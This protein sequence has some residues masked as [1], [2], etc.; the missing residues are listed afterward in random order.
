MRKIKVDSIFT[1]NIKC[2]QHI[3]THVVLADESSYSYSESHTIVISHWT[4]FQSIWI[5]VTNGYYVLNV[6][7]E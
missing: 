5:G 4:Y 6:D 2:I 3:F 1:T 7:V